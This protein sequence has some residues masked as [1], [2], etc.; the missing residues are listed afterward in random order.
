[1][2][3]GQFFCWRRAFTGIT[4]VAGSA[5]F[6][7]LRFTKFPGFLLFFPDNFGIW[8]SLPIFKLHQNFLAVQLRPPSSKSLGVRVKRRLPVPSINIIYNLSTPVEEET[9]AICRPSGDQEGCSELKRP[10]VRKLSS[11][12]NGSIK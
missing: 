11:P 10:L 1:M 4:T 5:V 3:H 6:P 2:I 7:P 12:V 8:C 9:K